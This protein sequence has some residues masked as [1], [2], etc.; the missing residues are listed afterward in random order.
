MVIPDLLADSDYRTSLLAG[1]GVRFYAGAPLTTRE[2]HGLGA[3]CVLGT[4]PRAVTKREIEALNDLAK[5][6]MAQI[7]LQHAFGRLDPVSGLPNRTQFLEDLADLGRDHPGQQRLA[8]FVDLAR[9]EQLDTGLRVMGAAFLDQIVQEAARTIA[10]AIGRGHQ[11]YHVAATQFAFLAPP[12]VEEQAYLAALDHILARFRNRTTR[13]FI[14]ATSIGVAPFTAGQTAPEAV[15][16]TAHSASQDARSSPSMVSVYS[17]ATDSTHQ[18]RF[19]LLNDFARA[20]RADGELSLLFQPRIDLA[21]G[22]CI[23][24]EALL[25]WQH[26]ELGEISPAEFIPAVEQT[27]LADPLTRW[28]IAAALGQLARWRAAGIDLALSVNISAANLEDPGF[29]QQVQLLLIKHRVRPEW[30]EIEV[31]E[32]AILADYGNATTQLATLVEAGLHVAID[33]FGT[34][35]SSLAYLQKLPGH[36]LKIDQSFVREVGLGERQ[37]TLVRSMISLAHDLG[38]RVV[39]EGVETVQVE[40]ALIAMG[41]DEAQGYLYGRPMTAGALEEWLAGHAGETPE[42]SA[43]A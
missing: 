40:E 35:Y 28:V 3:L 10:A 14:M 36:I 22:Q 38:Y 9:H 23:S 30:V 27:S 25:R 6:V 7:E 18:R 1:Q 5:M 29:A 11:A 39:G 16:R 24:V 21:T 34:G 15:L 19:R 20:L 4:E 43:A 37:R 26:P 2:G 33:D 41:C 13:R 42:A 8:V 32:S 12:E 31:T 17:T